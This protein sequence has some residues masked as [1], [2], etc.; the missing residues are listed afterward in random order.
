MTDPVFATIRRWYYF[1]PLRV[2]A[3]HH[4]TFFEED[5]V[6]SAEPSWLRW[7]AALGI[8]QTSVLINGNHG[9]LMITR[10]TWFWVSLPRV[11]NFDEIER[12]E[13]SYDNL[14]DSWIMESDFDCYILQ[15]K[16]FSGEY[17]QVLQWTGNMH[18]PE[19]EL[20]DDIQARD[21]S[22]P[23]TEANV[24]LAICNVLLGDYRKA[25]SELYSS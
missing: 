21:T 15:A 11:I 6:F 23:R 12:F 24:A 17:V 19:T 18:H 8:G 20:I 3:F 1:N 10:K 13:V 5:R 2:L 7:L 14:M 16:L 9:F 22:F 4:N 25:Q